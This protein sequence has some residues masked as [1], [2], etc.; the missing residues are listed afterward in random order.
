ME[1]KA[2]ELRIGNYYQENGTIYRTTPDDI[3][4]LMRCESRKVKSDMQP[5]PLK[6]ELLYKCGFRKD[7]NSGKFHAAHI[8]I[9]F[10]NGESFGMTG[11]APIY[12][13]KCLHHL[14]NIYYDL[15]GIELEVK[16]TDER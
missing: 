14:Q 16:L 5:I 4:N 12:N 7:N 8:E 1:I 2:I 15:T 3:T 11:N 9:C 13:L 10:S 6:E